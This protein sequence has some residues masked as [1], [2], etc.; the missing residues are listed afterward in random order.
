M[1]IEVKLRTVG[2][3]EADGQLGRQLVDLED[4]V[5]AGL[6]ALAQAAWAK[7][8]P[9]N[10]K[11]ADYPAALGELVMTDGDIRVMLPVSTSKN[12][13]ECVGVVVEVDHIVT[14]FSAQSD[15][16]GGDEDQVPEGAWLYISTG[17]GWWRGG[18]VTDVTVGAGLTGGGTGHVAIGLD[19]DVVVTTSAL[20]T[21]MQPVRA[22]M[23]TLRLLVAQLVQLEMGNPTEN[24]IEALLG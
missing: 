13:G 12:A 14:T 18:G 19:E 1:G 20:N 16:Q 23:E 21:A 8:R 7:L 9:T 5:N 11:T 6:R 2:S 15:A 10:T 3:F 4:N 24:G 17:A 22:S